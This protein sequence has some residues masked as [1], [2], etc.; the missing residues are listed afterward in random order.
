MEVAQSVPTGT[1][2]QLKTCMEELIRTADRTRDAS[3]IILG[4]HYAYWT[5]K[6]LYS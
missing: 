2:S 5:C 6:N 3:H 1:Q 4:K